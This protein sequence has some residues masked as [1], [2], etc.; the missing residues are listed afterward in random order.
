MRIPRCRKA[1]NRTTFLFLHQAMPK[2]KRATFLPRAIDFLVEVNL[3][4]EGH[5]PCIF[6]HVR[7]SL[8]SKCLRNLGCVG[9]AAFAHFG[10][11]LRG[12]FAHGF[13]GIPHSAGVPLDGGF[14]FVAGNFD[15]AAEQIV[16]GFCHCANEVHRSLNANSLVVVDLVLNHQVAELFMSL[17]AGFSKCCVSRKVHGSEYIR[18]GFLGL[19]G[20]PLGLDFGYCCSHVMFIL[21][22]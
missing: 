20:F 18:C 2:E 9:A 11:L 12:E 10:F 5:F 4:A 17:F 3:L 22:N 15:V 8:E 6:G 13:A 1:P 16:L 7:L 21:P 19:F 14:V